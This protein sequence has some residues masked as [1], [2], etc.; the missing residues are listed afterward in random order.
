[1]EIPGQNNGANNKSSET[2]K[3]KKKVVK[4]KT[5]ETHEA[6]VTTVTTDV[7]AEESEVT[8][9][10]SLEATVDVDVDMTSSFD[11]DVSVDVSPTSM[12]DDVTFDVVTVGGIAPPG[13]TSA[14]SSDTVDAAVSVEPAAAGRREQHF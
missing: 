1:M 12:G 11:V 9:S 6:D 10:F 5:T 7:T 2:T 8:S 3:K 13:E 14:A 4:K